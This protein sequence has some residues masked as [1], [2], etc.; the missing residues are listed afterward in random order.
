MVPTT[1]GRH[2]GDGSRPSGSSRTS[3]SVSGTTT[4][5]PRSL[6]HDIAPAPGSRAEAS[7]CSATA[8]DAKHA[9]TA[10]ISQPTG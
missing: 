9:P 7:H 1:T 8:F 2:R 5:L 6:H 10:S 4:A 3:S